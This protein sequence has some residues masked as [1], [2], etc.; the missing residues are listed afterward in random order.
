MKKVFLSM[1]ALA[2]I[3]ASC[4]NEEV[5]GTNPEAAIK[6]VPIQVTQT[7]A[8][9]DTKAPVAT[10][11]QITA[12]VLMHDTGSSTADWTKF[13]ANATNKVSNGSFTAD[14][15]RATVSTATFNAVTEADG[16][17]VT[18]AP[19]L[20]YP[21]QTTSNHSHL[22][23]VSPTGTTDGAKVVM[24]TVDGQQDV[25]FAKTVDAGAGSESTH[26]AIKFEFEHLTTQLNFKM[27][28][29]TTSGGASSGKASVKS[30]TIVDAE[31]P[32]AVNVATAVAEWTDAAPF[33]V[34]G[35]TAIALNS[36]VVVTGS[37]VMVKAS[38]LVKLNVIVTGGDNKDYEYNDVVVKNSGADLQTEAGSAHVITLTV[39]EP[40]TASS[41][42]E[43]SA[44]ATVKEWTAGAAGSADLK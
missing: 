28:L 3:M 33:V 43:I 18:L 16:A 8:G 25:M 14:A 13:V 22:A 38:G 4:S 9:I 10:G 17:T 35:I 37:P 29:T 42:T 6:A 21:T 27:A 5:P 24:K 20:Y 30:I 34:P 36:T 12:T 26:S 23:A 41:A 1:A 7:V 31:L 2:L 39:T 11:Q 40:Q 19:S 15:D 44:T 32:K